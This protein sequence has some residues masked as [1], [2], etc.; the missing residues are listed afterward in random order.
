MTTDS[1]AA[2]DLGT[3]PPTSTDPG[4]ALGPAIGRSFSTG[5]LASARAIWIAAGHDAAAF[6]AAAAADGMPT[7]APPSAADVKHFESF[8]LPAAASPGDFHPQFGSFGREATPELLATV[9]SEMT[10]WAAE[11]GFA[12]RYGTDVIEHLVALGPRLQGMTQEARDAWVREQ[13]TRGLEL[14]GSEA[15]L[16]ELRNRAKAALGF[17][18]S[19]KFSTAI[20]NSM[21]FHDVFFLNMLAFHHDA[22]ALADASRP[23]RGKQ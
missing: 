22:R 19:S 4:A 7:I 12:G 15:K 8:A 3:S 1:Q 2:A 16:A 6:D 13:E 5:E 20:E 23:G 18:K 11:M 9:T 14:A 10:T 21:A 17:A